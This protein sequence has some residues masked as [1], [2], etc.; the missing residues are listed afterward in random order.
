[1][2]QGVAEKELEEEVVVV[3]QAQM[4]EDLQKAADQSAEGEQGG[5]ENKVV[6]GAT[7]GEGQNQERIYLFQWPD[8]TVTIARAQDEESLKQQMSLLGSIDN[9][10]ITEYTG[11]LQ[12][13]LKLAPIPGTRRSLTGGRENS[14]LVV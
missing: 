8:A 14:L 4:E 11:P 12:I 1:M 7:E 13:N 5:E 2:T 3:E 10:R 9:S 6:S